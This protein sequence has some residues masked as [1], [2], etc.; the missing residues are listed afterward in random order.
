MPAEVRPSVTPSPKEEPAAAGGAKGG[1]SVREYE[2]RVWD[3]AKHVLHATFLYVLAV[4]VGGTRLLFHP[5]ADEPGTGAFVEA[6]IFA[7]GFLGAWACFYSTL[8][9]DAGLRSLAIT[10]L[11]PLAWAAAAALF[12]VFP[13]S[14]AMTRGEFA[15]AAALLVGPGPIGWVATMVRWRRHRREHASVLGRSAP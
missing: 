8:L 4:V 12:F 7:A 10:L 2:T 13:E 14:A 3:M 5:L 6:A 9:R 11:V 1:F 15:L